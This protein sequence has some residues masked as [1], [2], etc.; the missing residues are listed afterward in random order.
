MEG[1]RQSKYS[2]LNLEEDKVMEGD[3]TEEKRNKMQMEIHIARG[4]SRA[5]PS[6]KEKRAYVQIQNFSL[7]R[8]SHNPV[9]K[10]NPPTVHVDKEGGEYQSAQIRKKDISRKKY[11]RGIG[12]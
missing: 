4:G 6:G 2:I 10:I 9:E 3:H 8:S 7:I 12:N 11:S 1:V 5:L